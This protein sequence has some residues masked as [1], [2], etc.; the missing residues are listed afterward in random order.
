MDKSFLKR[1]L[2]VINKH[3]SE[4]DFNV[5]RFSQ[6]MA[7]SRQ[8][9]HRKI[10]ALIGQSATEFLR[11]VRLNKSAELLARKSGTVSEIAYDVG[12]S[13]QS[14]FTR[15]FRKLFGQSPSAY[16]RDHT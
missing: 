12:F 8:A 5:N 13:S 14:Y 15:S 3:L 1:S 11:F 9:L 10:R 16:M 4:P 2:D 6:E 7:M